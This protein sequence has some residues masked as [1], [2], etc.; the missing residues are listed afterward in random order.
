MDR[1][2]VAKRAG[3]TGD[4]RIASSTTA[5]CRQ[6]LGPTQARSINWASAAGATKVRYANLAQ[7]RN[8]VPG[9]PGEDCAAVDPAL[10]EM[11]RRPWGKMQYK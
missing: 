6:A 9:S 5:S 3:R 2:R 4:C 10:R 1:N 11:R 7:D 8:Q